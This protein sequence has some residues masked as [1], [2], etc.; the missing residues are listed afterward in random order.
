MGLT[1]KCRQ[2]GRGLLMKEAT[3]KTT[4]YCLIDCLTAVEFDLSVAE[5][6]DNAVLALHGLYARSQGRLTV[7]VFKPVD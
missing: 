5:D 7:Q 3:N 1:I 6:G 4:S 2:A